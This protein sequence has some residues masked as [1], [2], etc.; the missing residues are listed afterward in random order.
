[1]IVVWW[2]VQHAAM[3]VV[4]FS[5]WG[6][7]WGGC[8]TIH[9]LPALFFFFLK[10]RLARAHCFHSLCQDRSTVAQRAETTMAEC[11]LTSC[12]WAHFLIDSH[13]L[14]GQPHSQPT[15]TSMGHGCTCH[16]HFWQ[17]DW[18]L[19]HATAVTWGWKGH[20]IRVS[21]QSWLW[22]RKFSCRFCQD[23]NSQP[24]DH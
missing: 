3:V 5:S 8:L 7:I 9:S 23:S 17:N 21:T 11:S 6:R 18:G 22:R 24:F 2:C 16:L 20:R 1:M 14:P 15:P 4:A 19:L 13:T 10:W 12:M